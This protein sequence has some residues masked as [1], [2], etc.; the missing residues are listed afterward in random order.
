MT[1]SIKTSISII[2]TLILLGCG[3]N[4]E[5]TTSVTDEIEP[6]TTQSHQEERVKPLSVQGDIVADNLISKATI[7]WDI[8]QNNILDSSEPYTTS[9][10]L[11]H[12]QLDINGSKLE[13]ENFLRLVA[14]GGQE[15]GVDRPFEDELM[16]I[17]TYQKIIN[18]TPITTLI[19]QSIEEDKTKSTKSLSKLS[20]EEIITK[21][22]EIKEALSRILNIAKTLLESNPLT[23]AQ[24][25]KP[26][27]LQTAQKLNH[28]TREMKKAMKQE[29][30]ADKR[31][32][33]SSYRILSK[34]LLE[35]QK[36]GDDAINEAIEK[37]VEDKTIFEEQL[38]PTLKTNTKKLL[39]QINIFWSQHG[40]EQIDRVFLNRFVE[41]L[42]EVLSPAQ[43]VSSPTTPPASTTNQ[44]PYIPKDIN[45]TLAIRF[46][47][48]ATFG[49]TKESIEAIQKEG[50]EAWINQQL[51]IAPTENIYLRKTIELAKQAE[52]SANPYSVDEYLADNDK[53]FN[54]EKASFQ[55]PRYRLSAWFDTALLAGDQL[56]H[57]VTYA[58]SQIIVESDFEPIFTRRGEALARYFDILYHNAFGQYEELL[59]DISF[60]S[61][62]GLF[63]TYN[64]NKKAYLNDANVTVYPDEN[65]AREIMQLFSIGLNE[66]NLDGTPKKDT[67]GN[68]IP[69]YTQED[70]N[71]LAK[72]FTGW[73]NKRSGA[74]N[75]NRGDR[76]GRVGFTRGDFTHP[77]EFTAKYHDFG[78][79]QVLGQSI[80][81]NLSGEEDIKK[82]V[83][84]IMSNA[85]VAP[86]ISKNLIMRLAKSNPSP[87][88]I[89]RVATV[90]NTTK[91][92]LA[93]VTKAILLDKE[94]WS[95][96]IENRVI[97][98]KEPQIAY[99]NF[100]RAFKADRFP[101]WYYCGYGGPADDTASNCEVVKNSFLFNDTREYLGEGAGLAPTVFNFYDNNFVPNSSDFKTNNLVAPEIQIQKDSIFI[102]LSNQIDNLFRWEK[103]Y[104]I[105]NY[106]PDYRGTTSTYKYYDRVE[107]F[108]KD[109]PARGYVP[110]YYIGADKMLLDVSEELCVMEEVIDGDCNGDFKNLQHY[111]E[112]DY[113]DDEKALE[114]LISHL[115]QKLTG[116]LLSLAEEKIIYN[117]LAVNQTLK[118]FNKYNVHEDKPQKLKNY[119]IIRN[120]IKPVIRA[121]V[122]SST[123]MTE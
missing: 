123:F 94:L 26:E 36:S 77:M 41:E 67:N 10:S 40:N 75:V 16:A 25:G 32:I 57:K 59:N 42:Q 86:Y 24:E 48:K 81:A 122:T 27:A 49:A 96:L 118:L 95:D 22:E 18:L 110:V 85:N 62:M 83:S 88:Y 21:L 17:S 80:P 54:K 112:S 52:P 78:E 119:S 33:L 105:N 35:T 6:S 66:L 23:L 70:V 9:D 114:V 13:E 7:F 45:R 65:Y 120:A 38:I 68:L 63:L 39:N 97:K 107:D 101:S 76:F 19:A 100:L 2:A 117:E 99:T 69:T 108:I 20:S 4:K 12:Y 14:F 116:G 8:N 37:S 91:G 5:T 104:I 58:L 3:D 64:G 56:R 44:Y 115:N 34:E 103:N 43:E 71:N 72:V 113:H 51:S 109:A 111:A 47:N 30:R 28:V 46:L 106:Y 79:K 50:V 82:A 29:L 121:I 15:V 90:F 55:S 60:S 102:N 74:K 73:D 98:F 87:E 53:V 93:E 84:I 31:V 1:T 92:N 11:G 61:G 89:K